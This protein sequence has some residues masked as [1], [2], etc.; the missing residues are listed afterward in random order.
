MFKLNFPIEKVVPIV[1]YGWDDETSMRDNNTSAFNYRFVQG[2]EILSNHSYG[3]AIDI[4]P[5]F[6]PYVKGSVVQP[7]GATYSPARSGTIVDKDSVVLLFEGV[8]WTWGGHWQNLKD[9]QHFE[10]TQ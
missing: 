7:H 3:R 4:N 5:L 8:G 10:R 1:A 2:T 9:Y 6:N